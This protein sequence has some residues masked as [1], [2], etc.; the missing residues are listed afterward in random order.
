[1]PL[2]SMGDRIRAM[3]RMETQTG[4]SKNLMMYRECPF[5]GRTH[6]SAYVDEL[7]AA[8]M[9]CRD[10]VAPEYRGSLEAWDRQETF[11]IPPEVEAYGGGPVV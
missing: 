3:W 9:D 5:C 6:W 11:P 2:R 4:I 1:M 7:E 8:V 10:R